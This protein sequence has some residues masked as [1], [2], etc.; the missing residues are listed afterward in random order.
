MV[1]SA[2][3]IAV[4][5]LR[6]HTYAVETTS[7]NIANA[8]TPGYHRQ[9]VELTTAF[10]RQGGL[11]PMGAG[12][13]AKAI[14]RA[15]DRM[16]D[17]RVRGSTAQA[18]YFGTR[19]E[20]MTK[21]EDVFGE[22]DQ[23]IAKQLTT[24]WGAFATLSVQP[25]D[26]AARYQALSA[27][28]G[29]AARVNEIRSGLGQLEADALQRLGN[30]VSEVNAIT[31]RLAEINR[32]ARVPG[33]LP[34]DLADERDRAL[35]ALASTVGAA[36]TLDEDGR[37]RVTLS[38]LALVDEELSVPLSVG[39]SPP[40]QLML[41]A[42]PV[43]ATG[44]VGGLQTAIRQDIPNQR[45][46]LDTFVT[47]LVDAI[48]TLH[49]TGFTPAGTP[50]G[51]LL[52]DN[53]TMLVVTTNDPAHLAVTDTLGQV[54]NGRV[55]DAIAELRAPQGEAFRSVATGLAATVAGLTRSADSA[56]AVADAASVQRD[57]IVGVNIDE[58]M[59]DLLT[60]QR[61]YE[62]AARLV[63]VIDEMLQTLIA[64]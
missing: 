37:V 31:A 30:D 43:S 7:H 53:G 10:P 55:A 4:S 14:T 54:Q 15:S 42:A 52:S 27:L 11:G 12:V 36:A 46:A 45:A 61:A 62:A 51:P 18:N 41:R 60:Q 17:L 35:D 20:I 8:A 40:G 13:E 59:T 56:Q 1:S 19:A 2:L 58:E 5:A 44:T 28:G 33:G 48:N 9:R 16:A 24:L 47:G 49:A 50:G 25:A 34:A 23:G 63:S 39:S 26:D 32:F 21:A 6:A 3:S 57:S 29:V 64:M 22:P 38:G